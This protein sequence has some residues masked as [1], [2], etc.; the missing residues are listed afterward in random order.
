MMHIILRASEKI[1]VGRS[2]F[3]YLL[4]S[5][6]FTVTDLIYVSLFMMCNTDKHNSH[7]EAFRP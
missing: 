7:Q 4:V 2:G 1:N 6:A 5:H 3:K